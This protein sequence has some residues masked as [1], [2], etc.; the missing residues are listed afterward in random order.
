[1]QLHALL[2]ASGTKE[3]DYYST[4]L[5]QYYLDNEMK[6]DVMCMIHNMHRGED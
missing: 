6:K 1:M 2:G 5:A 3:T 4:L